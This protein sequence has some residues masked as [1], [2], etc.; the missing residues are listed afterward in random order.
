MGSATRRIVA[1]RA[2]RPLS[3]GSSGS[4]S[5]NCATPVPTGS[6]LMRT[7]VPAGANRV[8]VKLPLA[9]AWAVVK[10]PVSRVMAKIALCGAHRARRPVQC[11]LARRRRSG[12]ADQGGFGGIIRHER[13]GMSAHRQ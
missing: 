1:G 13:H 5:T 4:L 6:A 3:S 10:W 9:V 2:E 8:A 7:D 12:Y 11:H